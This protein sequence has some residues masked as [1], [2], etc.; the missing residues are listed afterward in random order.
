M[1][2]HRAFSALIVQALGGW[3]TE[4][5]MQ[6]LCRGDSF[7]TSCR[8]RGSVAMKQVARSWAE[9]RSESDASE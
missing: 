3:K 4:R 5:M 1:A 8:C 6:R 9:G 7:D 2:L